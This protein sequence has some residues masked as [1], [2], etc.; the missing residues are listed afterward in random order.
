MPIDPERK[1][2]EPSENFRFP[3]IPQIELLRDYCKAR[4]GRGLGRADLEWLAGFVGEFLAWS[5]TNCGRNEAR[6]AALKMIRLLSAI[7]ESMS[8]STDPE[9][10]WTEI[11]LALGL[12]SI[13][14][15]HMTGAELA[16]SRG[17]SKMAVSKKVTRFLRLVQLD[18]AF[19]E[20]GGQLVFR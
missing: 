19:N 2:T 10:T 3:E 12:P 1:W 15:S 13:C 5:E 16:S 17:I 7:D 20:N 8:A 11:S 18:R 9:R 4:Y 6:A 14:F